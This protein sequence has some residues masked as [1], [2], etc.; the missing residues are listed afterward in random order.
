M[1]MYAYYC[2]GKGGVLEHNMGLWGLE[3]QYG[4]LKV[5]EI[6]ILFQYELLWF[7]FLDF[8]LL[9]LPIIAFLVSSLHYESREIQFR[10]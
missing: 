4:K 7:D 8:V 9:Y 2:L 5:I 6:S 3:L 10:R 1:I